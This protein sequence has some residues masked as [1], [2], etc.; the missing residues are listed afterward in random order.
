MT[1]SRKTFVL[2]HGAWHGGWCWRRVGDRLRALGHDVRTP[3]LTGVG[4]RAHLLSPAV[5]LR[6]H[7]DDVVNVIK[8]DELTDVVLVGHSYGG[9]IVSEVVERVPHAIASIVYLDAFVP[10]NGKSLQDY[11]PPERRALIEA[12]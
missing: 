9:F 3:T 4:E 12:G 7:V 10:E 11:A 8:W 1:V 6:T 2:V 5:T